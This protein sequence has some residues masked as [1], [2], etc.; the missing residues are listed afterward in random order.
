VAKRLAMSGEGNPK[1]V[2]E[3]KVLSLNLN[4]SMKQM[5]TGKRR[6]NREGRA[7]RSKANKL[8]ENGTWHQNKNR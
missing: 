7:H 6:R 4:W 3:L 2:S 8:V 5:H 1:L